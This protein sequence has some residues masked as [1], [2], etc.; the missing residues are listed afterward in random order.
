MLSPNNYLLL[1]P[2]LVTKCHRMNLG[3]LHQMQQEIEMLNGM[4]AANNNMQSF[5]R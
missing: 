3:T 5:P 4:L 2:P 1:L